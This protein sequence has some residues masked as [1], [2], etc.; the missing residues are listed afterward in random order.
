MQTAKTSVAT[1]AI[2]GLFSLDRDAN[3]SLIFTVTE[4][5]VGHTVYRLAQGELVLWHYHKNPDMLIY[6]VAQ[7]TA[8][9]EQQSLLSC[10]IIRYRHLATMYLLKFNDLESRH[11]VEQRELFQ[12]QCE[13]CEA[14]KLLFIEELE[15]LTLSSCLS[16]AR[17]GSVTEP[18]PAGTAAA[19]LP[20]PHKQP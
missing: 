9:I 15:A 13:Q 1:I 3:T 17:C 11:S 14:L 6:P 8:L 19:F 4:Q 5:R 10:G 2:G 7:Y 18:N 20:Q 12:F 16:P